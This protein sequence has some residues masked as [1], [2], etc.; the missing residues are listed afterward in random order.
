MS[1]KLSTL[2]TDNPVLA[3]GLTKLS[4]LYLY[5]PTKSG[6][7]QSAGAVLGELIKALA[8]TNAS[9][10]SSGNTT[11]TPGVINLVHTEVTAITGSGSTTRI[12]ILATSNA[13]IAGAR[14]I[15][16]LTVP[17]TADIT[18]E[19]RNATSGGTLLT[20]ALSDGSGD[21]IV[22]EFYSDGTAW[23]F[24]RLHNPANAS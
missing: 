8:S 11:I 24:L 7:S 5:D 21:D 19:W 17:T 23:N 3:A 14:I 2:L 9:S 18:I 16:R 10:N 1:S 20:S 15:H 4:G 22:A 12:M 13:P 6:S